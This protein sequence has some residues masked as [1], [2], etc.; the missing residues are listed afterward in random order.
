MSFTSRIPHQFV[1]ALLMTGMLLACAN[2]D[3]KATDTTTTTPPPSSVVLPTAIDDGLQVIDAHLHPAFSGEP[4]QLSGIPDTREELIKEMREAGVVGGVALQGSSG[5][6]YDSDLNSLG[7]IRCAGIGKSVDAARIEKGLKTGYYRCIKI[8]LGYI[9]QYAYDRAYEPAYKLAEKYDVPVVFHT[10]DTD[11]SNGLLK[12]ADPLTI[13]EVAVKHRRVTF[14]IAH[15][16]NPWIESA[17]EVAYKNANVYLD[18]SA[19][20]ISDLTKPSPDAIKRV[21][22]D[23]LMWIFA[24]I[25]DPTKLMFGSDWPLVRIKDYLDIFKKAIPREHWQA[26]FHDNAVRI[27]KMNRKQKPG[28]LKRR[29]EDL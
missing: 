7:I 1:S 25:E 14:V 10:G 9:Y 2:R 13:D 29:R 16:G 4:D 8:Y 3:T 21:M 6:G 20:L 28:A 15:C 18:G 19:F 23:P 5:K 17:A 27:F 26:V 12:Y 11:D 22:I 24:Y